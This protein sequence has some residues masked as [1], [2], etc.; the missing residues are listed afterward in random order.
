VVRDAHTQ[1]KRPL[2]PELLD[3]HQC[4]DPRL[5]FING[6]NISVF[7]FEFFKL[8]DKLARITPHCCSFLFI[9]VG[10]EFFS[11]HRCSRPRRAADV[12]CAR[13]KRATQPPPTSHAR[14]P[15]RSQ[16]PAE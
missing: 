16:R 5:L 14:R 12:L 9:S 11:F 8:F 7:V 10:G 6:E 13:R 1:Q 4:L 15:A 2:L 3:T